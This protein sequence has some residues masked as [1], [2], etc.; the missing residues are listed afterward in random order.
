MPEL[1]YHDPSD[2]T[3]VSPFDEVIRE[4]TED[5]DEDVFLACPYI[6]PDYL[7]EI[8]EETDGWRLLTDVQA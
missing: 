1:V 5:E 3:G 2:R 6:E 7:R 4:I 8:T